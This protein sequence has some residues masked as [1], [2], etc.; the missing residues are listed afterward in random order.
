MSIL[1]CHRSKSSK[2]VAR[3]VAPRSRVAGAP[4][5]QSAAGRSTARSS[6]RTSLE[7]D[8]RVRRKGSPQGP[9]RVRRLG[10]RDLG[11]EREPYDE[12]DGLP[13]LEGHLVSAQPHADSGRSDRVAD[14]RVLQ[15]RERRAGLGQRAQQRTVEDRPRRAGG[16]DA[17]GCRHPRRTSLARPGRPLPAPDARTGSTPSARPPRRRPATPVGRWVRGPSPPP[18]RRSCRGSVR[19]RRPRPR[20]GRPRP[21]P[22]PGR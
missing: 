17:A 19:R 15:R 13:R 8:D 9:R 3:R 18:C 2:P 5:R 4:P 7:L 21:A 1:A 16:V 10:V 12:V 11:V 6:P 22:G 14:V 20:R